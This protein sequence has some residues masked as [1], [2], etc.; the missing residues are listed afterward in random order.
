MN[1]QVP[2][3][4]CVH[5]T[6]DYISF[7]MS[8]SAEL[9]NAPKAAKCRAGR[10]VHFKDLINECDQIQVLG[11][12]DYSIPKLHSPEVYPH[13][14]HLLVIALSRDCAVSEPFIHKIGLC[15]W[16]YKFMSH[17]KTDFEA[18]RKCLATTAILFQMILTKEQMISMWNGKDT[19]LSA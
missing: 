10:G 17:R 15:I 4:T 11:F 8:F 6:R 2:F 13:H 5:I 14:P 9:H 18:W 19:I 3:W 16:P 7:E 1:R 12:H